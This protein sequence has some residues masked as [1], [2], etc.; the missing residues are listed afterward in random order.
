M[1]YNTSIE[2]F[3]ELLLEA[4][5]RRLGSAVIKELIRDNQM[6]R[7]RDGGDILPPTVTLIAYIQREVQS[8]SVMERQNLWSP[9]KNQEKLPASQT[10]PAP[11][12]TTPSTPVQ[13]LYDKQLQDL[14]KQLAALTSGNMAPPH[15]PL[16]SVSQQ[17]NPPTSVPNRNPNF[18]CYYCFQPN[19]SSNR[20]SLFSLDESK[21]LVKK[22]GR[23]YL[24]PNDTPI[25]WDTSRPIKEIVDQFSEDSKKT[26][27]TEIELSSCF[28]QLE[29]IYVPSLD[30]YEED[31]K[32][33]TEDLDN[34]SVALSFN[35]PSDPEIIFTQ[36]TNKPP[37]EITEET[38]PQE[39]HSEDQPASKTSSDEMLTTDFTGL[40]EKIIQR[41][42]EDFNVALSYEDKNS[43]GL[44]DF[45]QEEEYN[46]STF[47]EENNSTFSPINTGARNFFH[48]KDS[49]IS[50]S[51]FSAQLMGTSAKL[52]EVPVIFQP[53]NPFGDDISTEI[54]ASFH[55]LPVANESLDNNNKQKPA[56]YPTR[57]NPYNQLDKVNRQ[58]KEHQDRNDHP[59]ELQ[60]PDC[61]SHVLPCSNDSSQEA[62]YT[63][64]QSK[65][66]LSQF[67]LNLVGPIPS[68]TSLK[69]ADNRLSFS[70]LHS[71]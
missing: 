49:D 32:L 38:E 3:R 37:E 62:I 7:S 53:E 1:G 33:E 18:R 44:E 8:D 34:S 52:G 20:C 15:K 24:L 36:Q 47:I 69:A 56:D 66:E 6:I 5:S 64:N 17:A 14:T 68:L 9:E 29:E 50:V 67:T 40:E 19:H 35:P 21:G 55:V 16:D 43:D 23:S 30:S 45:S 39:F 65:S 28:G 4:L 25:A 26:A 59:E 27:M 11:R 63:M 61:F 22:E 41:M 70:V 31:N 57:F 54:L 58:N 12:I 71:F 10:K 2:E 46:I 13:N 48:M 60:E 51:S 42:M